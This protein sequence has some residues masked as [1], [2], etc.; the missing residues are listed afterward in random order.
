MRDS[1]KILENG[2]CSLAFYMAMFG[3]VWH[4]SCCFAKEFIKVL[5]LLL[6]MKLP[7]CQES[8]FSIHKNACMDIAMEN[9]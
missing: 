5:S 4:K 8:N 6:E 9:F 2:A 7:L 3:L 1:D